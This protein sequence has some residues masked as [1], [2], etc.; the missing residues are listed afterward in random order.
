MM[1]LLNCFKSSEE[2]LNIEYPVNFTNCCTNNLS[3][4]IMQ[5]NGLS[6][7]TFAIMAIHENVNMWSQKLNLSPYDF[8]LNLF[9][10]QHL[11]TTLYVHFVCCDLHSENH[12]TRN[13]L[14]L[15]EFHFPS[16]LPMIAETFNIPIDTNEPNSYFFPKTVI[17]YACLAFTLEQDQNW[18]TNLIINKKFSKQGL[19]NFLFKHLH[20]KCCIDPDVH[21]KEPLFMKLNYSDNNLVCLQDT[22][23]L[24][25][26]HEL[27][28]GTLL[29]IVP[30]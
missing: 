15:Y 23:S 10:P 17:T 13:N 2:N 27:S 14:Y 30:F 12:K 24:S 16:F 19:H 11:I 18:L 28:V 8:I 7:K 26:S 21:I 5:T 1:S 9:L 4:K 25:Y 29:F 20:L 6:L 3:T 22:F